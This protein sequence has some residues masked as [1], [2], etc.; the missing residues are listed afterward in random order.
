MFKKKSSK[1]KGPGTWG[2]VL[3]TGIIKTS[4]AG[5]KKMS[6]RFSALLSARKNIFCFIWYSGTVVSGFCMNLG[7]YVIDYENEFTATSVRIKYKRT[8]KDK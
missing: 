6:I 8:E 5:R 1:I 3:A 2:D 4:Y 7:S